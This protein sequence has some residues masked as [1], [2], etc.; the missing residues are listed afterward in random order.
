MTIACTLEITLTGW[1]HAGSGRSIGG[2]AD[3]AVLR[4][5]E[6]LPWIPGR[7][8]RG[9]VREA[10]ELTESLGHSPDGTADRLCGSRPWKAGSDESLRRGRFRTRRG[11]LRFGSAQLPKSWRD[12]A[13]DLK[14]RPRLDDLFGVFAQTAIESA[15]KPAAGLAK[16]HSLRTIEVAPPITLC[17]DLQ[18]DDTELDGVDWENA[19]QKALPLIRGLGASRH[20]GLGRV[21]I[22]LREGDEQRPRTASREES[23]GIGERVLVRIDLSGELILSTTS[24]TSGA[25]G[26]LDYIPGATLLGAVARRYRDFGADAW[27]VFHSGAVSFGNAYPLFGTEAQA[28]PALPVPFAW[29]HPKGDPPGEDLANASLENRARAEDDEA[30]AVQLE[31][32]RRG[33]VSRNGRLVKPETRYRQKTAID[34]GRHGRVRDAALFGY[35]SLNAGQSFLAE[36]RFD[37]DRVPEPL[38]RRVIESLTGG[39][40][41]IGRS[42]SAEYGEARAER[43]TDKALGKAFDAL[44]AHGR[45]HRPTVLAFL[46]LS[47]LALEDADTGAPTTV[48]QAA[49]FGLPEGWVLDRT[50]SFAR[51]RRYAPFN[52]KRRLFD[53]ERQVLEKGSVLVFRAADGSP[54]DAAALAEVGRTVDRGLGLYCAEGLG[55]VVLEPWCLADARPHFADRPVPSG[56]SW[57]ARP[58]RPDDLLFAWMERRYSERVLPAEAARLA[59]ESEKDFAA[60]Y[61]E[62]LQEA[63]LG[64]TPRQ[65]AAP[66]NAQWGAVRDLLMNCD[67]RADIRKALFHQPDEAEKQRGEGGLCVTGVSSRA[68]LRGTSWDIRAKGSDAWQ[69]VSF[70]D[71]LEDLLGDQALDEQLSAAGLIKQGEAEEALRGRLARLAILTLAHRMPRLLA[72]LDQRPHRGAA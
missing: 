19:L 2:Y 62:V 32:M 61:R 72:G 1:W 64:G 37:P 71:L 33:Y 59:D 39:P 34:R 23:G 21:Q 13:E 47:D 9:L 29:H 69:A 57:P 67:S 30:G 54:L 63:D 56:S 43:C 70:K 28:R 38:R 46:L 20:R 51:S 5:P 26:T 8:L 41:L 50:H 18:L 17:A 42:R 6:G 66:S 45:P 12:W 11:A 65:E 14:N 44:T 49:H 15:G 25:H 10:L 7:T 24:A 16:D 27:T 31:Q 60:L 58:D 55:R 22:R 4:S 53:A 35:A 48:P 3:A 52:G 68:W 40:L 36:I